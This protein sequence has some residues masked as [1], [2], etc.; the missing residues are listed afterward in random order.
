MEIGQ[1]YYLF[2]LLLIPAMIFL[3]IRYLQWRKRALHKF[4]DWNLVSR[5]VNNAGIIRPV[6]KMMP[7]LL[8]LMLIIV[9][10]SDIQS[11]NA[12]RM[13][14]HEGIDVAIVLDV[15]NSMLAT[16]EM[17]NRL[18]TA[19]QFVA[20]LISQ[21]PETRIAVL[22]FAGL[23]VLQ[24]P[25]TIDHAAVQLSLSTITVEH[26]PEQGSDIGA[27][28]LE[29][30]NALPENQQHYRAIILVSDGEDHEGK[31]QNAI[32]ALKK[33]RIVVC[34]AGIGSEA[35]A[36]IPV[37]SDGSVTLKK[38]RQGKTVISIFQDALL[39]DIAKK[40][41]GVYVKVDGGDKSAVK[42]IANQLDSINKN[43]FDEELLVPLESRFQWFLLPALVLLLIDF[44]ISKRKTQWLRKRK[45]A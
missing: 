29:A 32:Q 12:S 23:P 36:T 31:V 24:T 35:G 4:G 15:S 7:P 42:A 17:P 34:T 10:L 9:A 22:T 1:P 19:K 21:L 30:I 25:I 8:A 44:F 26:V 14:R 41:N 38:D 33:E 37:I 28:L 39:R 11:G 18:S 43:Q 40:C 16:D 13:I 6:V 27:A 20:E 45:T 3:F 2:A 5:L